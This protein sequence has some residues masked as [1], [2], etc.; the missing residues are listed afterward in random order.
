MT[1]T[2][3][4]DNETDLR[5]KLLV[6]LVVVG[7]AAA[8]IY[9]VMTIAR[10]GLSKVDPVQL[11]TL[12]VLTTLGIT[13]VVRVRIRAADR[14]MGWTEAAIVLGVA[15]APVPWVV[16]CAGLGVALAPVSSRCLRSRRHSRSAK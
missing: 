13:V 15:V 9:S 4:R 14:I 7:A 2:T 6:G 8:A 11:V 3:R 5:L 16:L 1:N 10:S 12:V